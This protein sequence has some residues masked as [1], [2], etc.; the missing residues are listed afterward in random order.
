MEVSQKAYHT[1]LKQHSCDED[2]AAQ[3][4][5]ELDDDVEGEHLEMI[6]LLPHLHLNVEGYWIQDYGNDG[7]EYLDAVVDIDCKKRSGHRRKWEKNAC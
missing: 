2:D 3:T 5:E 6:A 4:R 1:S 7:A